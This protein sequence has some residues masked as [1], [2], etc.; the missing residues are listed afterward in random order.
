MYKQRRG[1]N[2]VGSEI[3]DTKDW[4]LALAEDEN[5]NNLSA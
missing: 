2:E 3:T 4:F 5:F 1:A